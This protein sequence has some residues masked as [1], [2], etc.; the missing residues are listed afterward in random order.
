MKPLSNGNELGE[1]ELKEK[2]PKSALRNFLRNTMTETPK[3]PFD[4]NKYTSTKTVAKGF[5]NVALLTSNATQLRIAISCDPEQNQFYEIAIV[6]AIISIILQTIMAILSVFVRNEDINF[7]HNQEKATRI[8]RV[9]I[10]L[11]IL[12]AI[13]NVLLASFSASEKVTLKCV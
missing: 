9:L 11:A 3:D 10:I 5:L 4:A 7:E 6:F 1:R 8:N 13:V 12:T 2:Q